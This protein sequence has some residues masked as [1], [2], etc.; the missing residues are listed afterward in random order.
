MPTD[1]TIPERNGGHGG[2]R[3]AP[4]VRPAVTLISIMLPFSGVVLVLSGVAVAV[5]VIR[6]AFVL[7]ADTAS[8]IVTAYTLTYIACQPLFG[9]LG[10]VL[11]NR[12]V[13]LLGVACFLAGTALGI[14][15]R[16]LPTL[17]AAR[18]L[19]GIGGASVNPI[20]MSI[21]L[22]IFPRKRQGRMLATWNM[23]GPVTGT[24]GPLIAGFLL[25]RFHWSAIFI[26]PLV[27]VA[28]SIVLLVR[29]VP[30]ATRST[31]PYRDTARLDWL[32]FVLLLGFVAFFVSFLSSRPITG[33]EP[34]RDLRLGG[35]AALFLSAFV[36]RER[37]TPDP[38]VP[39]GLLKGA[40]FS[41]ASFC[42]T[43]RMFMLA[44]VNFLIPLYAN[45]VYNLGAG[46]TG[47]IVT[48]NA[49]C[50]L[51]TMRIG[52]RLIDRRISSLPVTVGLAMQGLFIGTLA[53]LPETE[54]IWPMFALV[55]G[56]GLSA[57][58]SLAPLHKFAL[59]ETEQGDAGKVAGLYSLIRFVGVLIGAALGGVVLQAGLDTGIP[60]I[61]AY[62]QTLLM[63]SAVGIG[64]A[65]LSWFLLKHRRRE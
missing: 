3:N 37:R 19:Q 49:F 11:G 61:A 21:V 38:F 54:S 9:R 20:S 33:I 64:G 22:D 63:F 34:L 42:A 36:L 25:E 44:G 1:S 45:D 51:V 40:R 26:I 46:V 14:L 24:V 59:G 31:T 17:L 50:L 13:L 39:V 23:V 53:M 7:D 15:S 58:L 48:T 10:D 12:R 32:G 57:G 41:G 35:P 5:P 47:L 30:Q 60:T 8:W 65:A 62:R 43:A 2:D 6:E 27:V 55:G 4:P 29:F 16:D 18:A 56:Q 28:G 52:G